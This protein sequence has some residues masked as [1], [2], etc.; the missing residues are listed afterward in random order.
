[1][2]QQRFSEQS[3]SELLT[4]ERLPSSASEELLQEIGD[5]LMRATLHTAQEPIKHTHE[6]HLKLVLFEKDCKPTKQRGLHRHAL[7]AP[8]PRVPVRPL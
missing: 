4:A 5:N 1:M 2:T 7:E 6:D 8:P 3:A